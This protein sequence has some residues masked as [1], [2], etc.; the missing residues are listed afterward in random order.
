ML[1]K[2]IA[3]YTEKRLALRTAAHPDI[4]PVIGEF[5][6]AKVWLNAVMSVNKMPV[7]RIEGK[8]SEIRISR[9]QVHRSVKWLASPFPVRCEP[10]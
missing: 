1:I 10:F 7:D 3:R 6:S 8:T 2:P 5:P 9:D 4:I